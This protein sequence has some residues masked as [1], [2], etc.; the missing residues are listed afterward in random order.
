MSDPNPPTETVPTE[1][2]LDRAETSW[3]HAAPT[4]APP[5]LDEIRARVRSSLPPP[6]PP[7]GDDEVDA[8]LS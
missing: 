8:W 4:L 3:F 6:A 7:M 2:D 1:E 5:S